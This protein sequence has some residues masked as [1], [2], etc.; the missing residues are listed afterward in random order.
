MLVLQ[1]H[2]PL[3]LVSSLSSTSAP[4][5]AAAANIV[6]AHHTFVWVYPLAFVQKLWLL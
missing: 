4:H 6:I 5:I 3:F 1:H 2:E